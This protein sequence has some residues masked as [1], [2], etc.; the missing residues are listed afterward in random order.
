MNCTYILPIRR[1][2][3]VEDDAHEL[4]EYMSI[5]QEAGCEVLVIDGSPNEVFAEHEKTWTDVCRHQPVDSRFRFLNDKVNGVLTGVHLATHEKIILADDD[6]RYREIDIDGVVELLDTSEIVRPQNFISPLLWWAKMEAARMLVNRATLRAAD[7]PGTCAFRRSTMLSAGEYDGDVLFDNEELVRHFA[8]VGANIC[9][10][11]DLFIRKRPPRFQKWLEQRPRQAY[12]D[13]GLRFKTILFAALLPLA[14]CTA[15][16]DARYLS[17]LSLSILL[18]FAGW[19]RGDARR[20]FPLHVCLFAPLW[21]IERTISTY[22]AFWWFV[23]RGGYPFGD[24][25]LSKGI[26]RDWKLAP[27]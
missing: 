8:R 7:Y 3:F 18:A 13:F 4:R 11:N 1:S 12:E 23:R 5:L 25:I 15:I 27:P 16:V 14:I 10:A 2:V 17:I 20:H 26:G 22:L 9:Y 6:I 19:L 24:R 21:V